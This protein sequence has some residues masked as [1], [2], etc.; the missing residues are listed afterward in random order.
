[1]DRGGTRARRIAS[2]RSLHRGL[3]ALDVQRAG[4]AAGA[5]Q[6]GVGPG[7]EPA[8]AALRPD[9]E[10]GRD[11]EGGRETGD[12]DLYPDRRRAR[13][14]RFSVP[15]PPLGGGG[16]GRPTPPGGGFS[17]APHAGGGAFS[18]LVF[19][20]SGAGGGGGGPPLGGRGRWV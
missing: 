1:M 12:D 4:L 20:P 7:R 17:T 10:P 8:P 3:R 9:P 6:D 14:G 11:R 13:V 5:D 18:P 15:P 19:G 2:D 16:A